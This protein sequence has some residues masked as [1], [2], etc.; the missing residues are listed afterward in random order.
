M[1]KRRSNRAGGIEAGISNG[2]ELVVRAAMKPLPTLM[3]PLDS[4]DLATGEPAQALVERS[5]VAAVEAL[6]VVAEAAVAWELARAAHDKL[7][8]DALVDMLAAHKAYL[9]RIRTR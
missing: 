5:D 2:E 1:L 6:A 8:G 4:V 9:E 7:G 3:R